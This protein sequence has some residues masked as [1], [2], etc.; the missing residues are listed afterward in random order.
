MGVRHTRKGQQIYFRI[1]R[2]WR[3]PKY[4]CVTLYRG[5]GG[6][7]LLALISRAVP[8]INTNTQ[9]RPMR[10]ITWAYQLVWGEACPWLKYALY[11]HDM[12]WVTTQRIHED[13]SSFYYSPR[14]I[15]FYT[16]FLGNPQRLVWSPT[17]PQF[18]QHLSDVLFL[19]IIDLKEVSKTLDI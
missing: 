18:L 14:I 10:K 2:S 11:N 19:D 16:L 4:L 8:A 7:D 13:L 17:R 5:E 1:E 6:K 12:W 15:L 3:K 9:A